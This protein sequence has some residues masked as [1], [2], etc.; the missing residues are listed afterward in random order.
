MTFNAVFAPAE[1]ESE[2]KAR[3]VAD[4]TRQEQNEVKDQKAKGNV[5]YRIA[6]EI[7]T[8]TL[9]VKNGKLWL[10]DDKCTDGEDTFYIAKSDIIK[11]LDEAKKWQKGV[12]RYGLPV[13]F[14]V[15]IFFQRH[16]SNNHK[17]IPITEDDRGYTIK[18]TRTEKGIKTRR[19]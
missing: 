13:G 16:R 8:L 2:A 15:L 18:V 19:V 3:R 1:T 12:E 9:D 17:Y 10:C 11:G 6:R 5:S 7:D 4:A 14:R